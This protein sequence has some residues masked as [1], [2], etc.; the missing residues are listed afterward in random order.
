VVTF[1][2]ER[3]NSVAPDYLLGSTGGWLS[4]HRFK[5]GQTVKY[6]AGPFG[7]A[8]AD[9]VYKVT[10]LLPPEGDE[11]RYRI[12]SASL[13]EARQFAHSRWVGR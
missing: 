6:A 13:L 5:V 9:F 11:Q 1:A 10:Q 12:K 3:F 4:D 8:E 7:R 2:I